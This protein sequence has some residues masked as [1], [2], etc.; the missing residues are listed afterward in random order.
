M[1]AMAVQLCSWPSKASHNRSHC[2]CAHA[3]RVDL[4][5][6][7]QASL[8][9]QA[10]AARSAAHAAG[11]KEAKMASLHRRDLEALAAVQQQ[12]EVLQQQQPELARA[13]VCRGVHV[14]KMGGMM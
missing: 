12:V 3:E 11:D 8:Q 2:C 5:L 1:A 10:D 6:S 7:Q 9:K 13:Q 14:Q 4:L